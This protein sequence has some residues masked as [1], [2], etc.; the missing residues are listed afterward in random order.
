MLIFVEK[1]SNGCATQLA[2]CAS[3]ES[4]SCSPDWGNCRR[5]RSLVPMAEIEERF[6]LFVHHRKKRLDTNIPL[7]ARPVEGHRRRAARSQSRARW[8]W[9]DSSSPS[10]AEEISSPSF[11]HGLGELTYRARERWLRGRRTMPSSGEGSAW[12]GAHGREVD[13][14]E[15]WSKPTKGQGN[16][17]LALDTYA[18][19]WA[20]CRRRRI[21]W[22]ISVH[23]RIAMTC[24]KIREL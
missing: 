24:F 17:V 13:G 15:W 5:R 12:G 8:R 9:R 4:S 11:S 6:H 2:S 10:F 22:Q 14:G 16:S 18:C 7:L 21:K 23:D 19:K 1:G 3:E 20:Q